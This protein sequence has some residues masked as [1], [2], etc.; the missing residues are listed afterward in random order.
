MS[1]RRLKSPISP[2]PPF[3]ISEYTRG[4]L[5]SERIKRLAPFS[6]KTALDDISIEVAGEALAFADAGGLDT[7]DIRPQDI[8]CTSDGDIKVADIE[9]GQSIRTA[10]HPVMTY[11][12]GAACVSGLIF[13]MLTGK[14]ALLSSE[15]PTLSPSVAPELLRTLFDEAFAGSITSMSE[16][17]SGLKSIRSEVLGSTANRSRQLQTHALPTSQFLSRTSSPSVT[18]ENNR[19]QA[20]A[21][22]SPTAEILPPEHGKDS[23]GH[24]EILSTPANVIAQQTI[25]KPV[26][27]RKPPRD[28]DDNDNT[29]E[30]D[31]GMNWPRQIGTR[32]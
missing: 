6:L 28:Y 3:L 27:Q 26:G 14:S 21:V 9:V 15:T 16:F 1:L 22:S 8:V 18:V 17:S 23:T 19:F 7:H 12:S 25:A 30:R 4:I 29:V 10:E 20:A 2:P 32:S 13:E 31:R 24:A 5:L 11:V